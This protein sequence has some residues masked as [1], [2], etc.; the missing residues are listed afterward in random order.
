MLE[1]I[2]EAQTNKAIAEALHISEY[3]VKTHVKNI[4]E[5]YDVASRAELI[6][7]VLKN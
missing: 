5:K 2:L 6:T 4:F 7:F 1:L 3:T